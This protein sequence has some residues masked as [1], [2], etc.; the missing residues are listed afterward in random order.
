MTLGILAPSAIVRSHTNLVVF[1][2]NV[3]DPDALVV[4]ER[5]EQIREG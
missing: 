1:R 4:I 3:E 5:E 2:D